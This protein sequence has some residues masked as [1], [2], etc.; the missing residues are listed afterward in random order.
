MV[1]Y[2]VVGDPILFENMLIRKMLNL[3]N[4]RKS[5]VFYDLG[6]GYAQNL[7]VAATEFSVKDC[8][9][10]EKKP[11]RYKEA[12]RRLRKMSLFK[13]ITIVNE[14]FQHVDLEE[15]DV[16]F[17]GLSPDHDIIDKFKNNLKKGCRLIYYFNTLLP[18]IKPRV[19]DYP[20]YVS[21]VPLKEAKSEHEWLSS[22]IGIKNLSNT[23][24]WR[25]LYWK[26]NG[27]GRSIGFFGNDGNYIN[28]LK[29]LL[30]ERV[31]L[32]KV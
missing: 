28:S 7:I 14:D 2:P 26:Y 6:C 10:I 11:M 30:R 16:V 23:K 24:L 18:A 20:F 22:I 8:I 27:K 25:E 12:L 9:G 13:K 1:K 29:R 32:N 5:D 19:I 21:I 15:A 17:Y 31:E 3:V 4:I